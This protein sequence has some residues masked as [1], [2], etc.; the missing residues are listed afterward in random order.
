MYIEEVLKACDTLYPNSYTSEE[1]YFWCDELSYMLALKYN[2]A[3]EK[4]ELFEK[5][6]S[7]ALP[8]GVTAS[9]IKKLIYGGEE[10]TD[11]EKH[12][13]ICRDRDG[14]AELTMPENNGFKRIYA[15]FAVPHK[16]IRN[17]VFEG[18]AEFGDGFFKIG[19][20]IFCAGDTLEITADGQKYDNITVL[21][22]REE[23]GEFVFS[24]K[25]GVLPEGKH[26]SVIRRRITEQTVCIPP[27]D[28]MYID[29]V[30]GRICYYQ[31]DFAACN[32]HMT[33]FNSKLDDYER[34]LK[35]N[36]VTGYEKS[37]FKNWW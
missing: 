17:A 31:N 6:G 37:R 36:P 33:A 3:Y 15:V 22:V 18:I 10:I 20:N 4:K 19:E 35:K 27:Y 7:F 14:R 23:D 26:D 24:V 16:K 21:G 2:I 5:D 25:A 13:I 9:L 32:N 28:S 30:L 11:I 8:E 1:K 34:W 12:G 29:Y